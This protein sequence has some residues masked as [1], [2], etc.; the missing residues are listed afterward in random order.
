LAGSGS[1]R[2]PFGGS[3][4][5]Y[6]NRW[7][8]PMITKGAHAYTTEQHTRA[9][10]LWRRLLDTHVTTA[11]EQRRG[12]RFHLETV[13]DEQLNTLIL[14]NGEEADDY[15]PVAITLVSYSDYGGSC[16]DA[17]NVRYFREAEAPG[18]YFGSGVHGTEYAW[19]QLGELPTNGEDIA[20][21]LDWL[22]SLVDMMDAVADHGLISDES[23]T[24]YVD[25]LAE[26]AWD[27]WLGA[28]VLAALWDL[29]HGNPEDFQFT[30]DEIRALYYG[31]DENWWS[32]ETATSVHNENHE[33]AMTHVCES[34]LSAWRAR[35]V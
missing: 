27:Q 4:I 13:T 5:T 2:C 15:Y 18:V 14:T 30:D 33:N 9:T 19:V 12:D 28:D 26:Q 6:R 16:L 17:A 7:E 32:C 11:H 1:G 20:T 10:Q 3:A 8:N 22:Q 35:L 29:S 23:H 31:Y 25:A 21:G 34:I 24:A